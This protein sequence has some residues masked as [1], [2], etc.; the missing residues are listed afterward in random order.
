MY[1]LFILLSLAIALPARAQVEPDTVAHSETGKPVLGVVWELPAQ[2]DLAIRDLMEMSRMGVEAVRTQVIRNREI[3]SFADTLGIA[4]YIDLPIS[5]LPARRFRDT[6]NYATAVLDTVLGLA[7]IHPSIRHI[8]L[9]QD[10]DATEAPA[11]SALGQLADHARRRGPAGTEVYYLTRFLS[12]DRCDD[13]VD[14]VLLDVRDFEDPVAAVRSRA[15]DTRVGVGALGTWVRSDTLRG[16]RVPSSPEAQARYFEDHLSILLSDTL[17]FAPR[18]VFVHRWR[19][20][21][22]PFPDTAHELEDPYTERYGLRTGAGVE[23]PAYDVVE[24]LYTGR[25]T[26][27]AF[28]GGR[29]SEAGAPWTTLF[30]WAVIALLGV[31]YALSPRFRHMLPR[32]FAARFFY[33]DAVREGRDVLFGASTVLLISLS[34]ACGITASV[35]VGVLRTTAPFETAIQ[36]LP[37]ST[38]DVVITLLAEPYV[39]VVLAGCAYAVALILWTTLLSLLSSRRYRIAPGQALMLAVWPRWPLLF[40]MLAAMVVASIGSMAPITALILAAAWIVVSVLAVGRALVDYVLVTHVPLYVLIPALILNP[41]IVVAAIIAL[42]ILP[43][44]PELT[45]LWSLATKG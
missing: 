44:K 43:F 35:I 22:G 39:L 40:V 36:W 5:N 28:S 24:G 8:G 20:I 15:A 27:F 17:S 32:Y 21:R 16:L 3:L 31:F 33:R 9:A 38:Q 6:L 26:T 7:Q 14:I 11:C 41:G 19:D 34:A 37:R 10:I 4:L 25:Q 42:S 23:R 1:K 45:F 2:T 30:G 13:A 12:S 18:V 29:Y